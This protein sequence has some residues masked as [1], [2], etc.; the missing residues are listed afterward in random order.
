LISLPKSNCKVCSYILVENSI[1]CL[2][3]HNIISWSIYFGARHRYYINFTVQ[4]EC[5]L[6]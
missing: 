1:W 6:M 5:L 3:C 2:S 4:L